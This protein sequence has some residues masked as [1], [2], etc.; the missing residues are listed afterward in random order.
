MYKLEEILVPIDF[1]ER[2]K[3]ALGEVAFLAKKA[4]AKLFAFHAFRRPGGGKGST[5]TQNQAL[6][7]YKIKVVKQKYRKAIQ[8]FPDFKEIEDYFIP[9]PGISIENIIEAVKIKKID[10]IVSATHGTIGF[11]MLFGSRTQKLIHELKGPILCMP[12]GAKIRKVKKMALALDLES[13]FSLEAVLPMLEMARILEAKLYFVEVRK[14]NFPKDENRKAIEKQL[15]A[16][17]GGDFPYVFESQY[18]E[19]VE[20]GLRKFVKSF[21]INLLGLIPL[22]RNPIVDLFHESLSEKMAGTMKIPILTLAENYE[23]R[24]L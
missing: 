11:D 2:S 12:D 5:T 20:E 10:L 4:K 23:L 24:D 9:Q 1:S 19:D 6:L 18:D 8:P 14:H 3:N 22:H 17:T 21:K 16:L 7:A 15:A 13:N